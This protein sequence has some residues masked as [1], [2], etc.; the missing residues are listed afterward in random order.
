MFR[1]AAVF[2]LCSNYIHS[3]IEGVKCGSESMAVFRSLGLASAAALLAVQ[4]SGV[5]GTTFL[6]PEQ[7]IV[8]PSSDSASNP[9]EWLGA[10]SPFFAGELFSLADTS[11][12]L[13]LGGIKRDG[14]C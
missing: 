8:L 2:F 14:E 13:R 3:L 9:L 1:T 11:A 6:A 4:L 7:N 5:E 12:E 10:N